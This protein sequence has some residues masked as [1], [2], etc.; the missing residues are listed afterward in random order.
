[1]ARL[2]LSGQRHQ[3]GLVHER[4]GMR[5]LAEERQ[6]LQNLSKS[7]AALQNTETVG[8]NIIG[9]RYEAIMAQLIKAET[10]LKKSEDQSLY[11]PAVLAGLLNE[12][13]SSRR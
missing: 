13:S 5:D 9:N 3:L 7:I 4:Y 1:L 8:E 2:L 11:N 10:M 6:Q 12:P